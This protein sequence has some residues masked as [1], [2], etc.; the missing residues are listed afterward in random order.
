MTNLP[1]RGIICKRCEKQPHGGIAQ[2]ARATGSYPVGHRF[3]SGFRYQYLPLPVWGAV[4]TIWP[5]GQAAKT[6]PFH[7]GNTGSIPVRVT[8]RKASL[9]RL[10]FLFFCLFFRA[11]ALSLP[12]RIVVV[13]RKQAC[14]VNSLL[15]GVSLRKNSHSGYFYLLTAVTHTQKR[16]RNLCKTRE[17]KKAVLNDNREY[18]GCWQN[19]KSDQN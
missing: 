1:L 16:R 3:K 10:A 2:L 13:C 8:I 4:F 12:S 11:A 5:G 6:P 19:M 7:G 14:F 15:C 18:F 17:S 9:K